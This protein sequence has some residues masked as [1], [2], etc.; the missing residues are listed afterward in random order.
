MSGR[1]VLW[2]V[3]TLA[4]VGCVESDGDKDGDGFLDGADCAPD[5]PAVHPDA[6]EVCNG[7]DDDCNGVPDDAGEHGLAWYRDGDGDGFGSLSEDPVWGCSQPE[8]YSPTRD[9]CDDFDPDRHPFTRWY[10]N[11]DGDQHGDP[12]RPAVASC[13]AV[14]GRIDLAG[15]CDDTDPTVHP[16]VSVDACNDRDDDCDGEIDEDN[17]Q[18][19]YLDFDADGFGTDLRSDPGALVWACRAPDGYTSAE[20]DC[21]D[22]DPTVFP[23]APRVCNDGI[24][25]S[26]DPEPSTEL[27]PEAGCEMGLGLAHATVVGNAEQAGLGATAGVVRDLY[28]PGH[29]GVLLGALGH[30]DSADGAQT[31][32]VWLASMDGI[33]A[34]ASPLEARRVWEVGVALEGLFDD[35]RVGSAVAGGLDLDSDGIPEVVVGAN[36]LDTDRISVLGGD[37]ARNGGGV[38]V[39]PGSLMQGQAAGARVQLEPWLMAYG[40]TTADWVGGGLATVDDALAV[41][42]TGLGWGTDGSAG[43]V[44]LLADLSFD[45]GP[46]ALTDTADPRLRA[47]VAGVEGESLNIGE[48]ISS[49]DLNNDGWA[50]LIIGARKAASESG[51]VYALEGPVTGVGALDQREAVVIEGGAANGQFGAEVAVSP[52]CE[53]DARPAWLVV[54]APTTSGEG[55]PQGGA[56][57]LFSAHSGF[58]DDTSV[59]LDARSDADT[60]ILGAEHSTALGFSLAAGGD[61]DGDGCGSDLV[62]GTLS[63]TAMPRGQVFAFVGPFSSGTLLHTEATATFTGREL[64]ADTGSSVAFARGPSA[65]VSAHDDGDRSDWLVIG[66]DDYD[67]DRGS[68]RTPGWQEDLGAAFFV[69]GVHW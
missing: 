12:D 9:D 4:A 2:L 19:Y 58:F 29:D 46:L 48:D 43:G 56:A 61:I 63:T 23:G 20:G 49:A 59:A 60:R 22:L 53:A 44:V 31:G 47:W 35:D 38:F 24:D 68:V 34:A 69:N 66:A 7:I 3:G 64:Y 28:G 67:S 45:D 13:W 40:D 11:E 50:D 33:A 41:G 26:C 21:N 27:R 51:H 14:E 5:D 30:Y 6:R 8:G 57:Y 25:N 55:V 17:H 16:S 10:V 36:K 62:L 15:D 1:R 65:D 39:V 32:A 18:P 42:A 37:G 52:A 54:T